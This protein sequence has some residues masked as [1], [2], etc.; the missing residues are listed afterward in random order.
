MKLK[1]Y[2]ETSIFSFYFDERPSPYIVARRG[3]TGALF[4]ER[5]SEFYGVVSE[6]VLD[7][8][9]V[10]TLPHRHAAYAL[11]RTFP[12]MPVTEDMRRVAA[13]YAERFVMPRNPLGDA[14]HLAAAS[15]E[16][17]DSLVTWNC[18]HLA[19]PNKFGHIRETNLRLG[20]PVPLLLT[21]LELLGIGIE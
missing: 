12:E 11:A 18:A 19:N 7:E 16:N 21:P 13:I 8:L 3:W 5:R 2:L 15:M 4:E 6:A 17:C 1:V 10:G 9:Q 20:L 14:L